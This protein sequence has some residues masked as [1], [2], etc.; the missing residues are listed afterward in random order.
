MLVIVRMVGKGTLREPRTVP[1]PTWQL[2]TLDESTGLAIVELPDYAYESLREKEGVLSV[3]YVDVDYRHVNEHLL[4]SKHVVSEDEKRG[5]V[6][7][8]CSVLDDATLQHLSRELRLRYNRELVQEP[9]KGV[10]SRE[11]PWKL[12]R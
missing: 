12:Q 3:E 10:N 8:A 1:L 11:V 2:A 5:T 9:I 7:L 4:T 6:T